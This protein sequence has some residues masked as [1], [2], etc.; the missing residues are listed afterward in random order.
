MALIIED[1]SIIANANSFADVSDTKA[2][3][4]LRGITTLDGL[5]DP[6]VEALLIKAMDYIKTKESQFKGDRVDVAQTLSWPRF[7]VEV[8]GFELAATDMPPTLLDAQRQLAIDAI[9]IDLLP[10]G[11]G[12]EVIKE[13]VDV[14]ETEFS[15]QGSSTI[16]PSLTKADELLAPLLV[17]DAAL[18]SQRI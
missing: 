15:E 18:R 17:G 10:T 4:T 3:A 16:T 14:I 1:G 6:E 12:R 9:G 5:T 2:Y 11:A 8:F 13:K 7:P